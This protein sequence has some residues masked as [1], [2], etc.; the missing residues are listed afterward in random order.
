MKKHGGLSLIE[1]MMTLAIVSIL[2][3]VAIPNGYQIYARHKASATINEL[4]GQLEF[5]RTLALAQGRYI[6]VCAS[7]DNQSCGDN[8]SRGLYIFADPDINGVIESPGQI[9]RV[10]DRANDQATIT[11]NAGLNINY[12]NYTPTG[13]SFRK[14]S[15]GNLVY[16]SRAGETRNAKVIIF[17][18]TGRAYLGRDR[19]G[20][21]IPEN[22]S[23]NDINC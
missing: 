3:F 6:S 2:Y 18:R 11:L 21:G 8:W 16:C 17:F 4:L 9:I 23:G 20:N 15:G 7:G 1:L 19:N 12:I 5:A 13:T 14:N 22:G 10:F